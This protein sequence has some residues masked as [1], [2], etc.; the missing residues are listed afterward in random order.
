[1]LAE[2]SVCRIFTWYNPPW[3]PFGFLSHITFN[4]TTITFNILNLL[5][6]LSKGPYLDLEKPLSLL[7]HPYIISLFIIS[8]NWNKQIGGK[9]MTRPKHTNQWMRAEVP[10]LTTYKHSVHWG[11]SEYDSRAMGSTSQWEQMRGLL[12]HRSKCR[13]SR[14]G[15]KGAREGGGGQQGKLCKAVIFELGYK[16]WS[17]R[18]P[19]S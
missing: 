12:L 17:E 5:W 11:L 4:S 10:M 3:D 8:T 18:F 16:K 13:D 6:W 2:Q 7:S 9:H 1:M 19:C 15:R 14:G